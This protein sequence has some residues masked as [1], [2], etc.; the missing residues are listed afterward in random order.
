LRNEKKILEEKLEQTRQV[1]SLL[2]QKWTKQNQMRLEGDLSK[3]LLKEIATVAETHI[4][5]NFFSPI[6]FHI[7]DHARDPLFSQRPYLFIFSLLGAFLWGLFFYGWKLLRGMWT[8]FPLNEQ[9]LEL[10]G[11]R[12]LGS[13]SC[14]SSSRDLVLHIMRELLSLKKETSSPLIGLFLKEKSEEIVS[15]LSSQ[16]KDKKVLFLREKQQLQ[17]LSL[18]SAAVPLEGSK[19]EVFY[20]PDEP[21]PLHSSWNSFRNEIANNYDFIF[22]LSS[23]SYSSPRASLLF[24]HSDYSILLLNEESAHQMRLF[25]HPKARFLFL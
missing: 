13:L 5:H 24:S 16:F 22:F 11:Q 15:L 20:N 23:A 10:W 17:E 2:P 7:L 8:G 3:E 19:A 12:S 21:F 4:V 18:E 6:P 25:F 1:S 14:L 9:S